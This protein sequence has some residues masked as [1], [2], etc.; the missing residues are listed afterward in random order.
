MVQCGISPKF[1]AD[2]VQGGIIGHFMKFWSVYKVG[3]SLAWNL[4]NWSTR[5]SSRVRF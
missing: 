1:E 4:G 3:M 5:E 2:E